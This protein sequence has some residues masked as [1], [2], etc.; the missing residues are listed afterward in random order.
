[1]TAHSLDDD[2]VLAAY[3]DAGALLDVPPPAAH[4]PREWAGQY[5]SLALAYLTT[6]PMTFAE[7]H[8]P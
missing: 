3:G 2:D 6:S 4:E 7:E 8:T 1:M 5:V